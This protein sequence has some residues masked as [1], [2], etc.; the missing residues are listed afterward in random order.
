MRQRVKL[1]LAVAAALAAALIPAGSA[2]ATTTSGTA[3][4]PAGYLCV[5]DQINYQG[6]MYKFSGENFSWS[7]WA[8]NNHDSSWYNHGVSGLNA[9][10][11][12]YEGFSGSVKV[13]KAGTSSPSDPAHAH[14]GS[15]N[16]WGKC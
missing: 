15:S 8:I 10:V 5:W 3:D 1:S 9:C 12:Q 2:G 16:N 4:C 7:A 11:W 14:Y 13:I 6:N